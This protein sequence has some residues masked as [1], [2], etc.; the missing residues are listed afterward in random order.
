MLYADRYNKLDARITKIFTFGRYRVQGSL[1]IVNVFN[2]STAN[3]V[4][5]TYGTSWLIPTQ[6]PGARQFRLAGQLDF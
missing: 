5:V 2:T 3:T 1:D 4:N 6:I